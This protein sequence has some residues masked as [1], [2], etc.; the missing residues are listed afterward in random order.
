MAAT[1]Q[2]TMR[3]AASQSLRAR[4]VLLAG[5]VTIMLCACAP[6]TRP[7]RAN[8]GAGAPVPADSTDRSGGAAES[9]P[10][11]ALTREDVLWLERVGF[12]VDDRLLADYRRL[13]RKGLLEQQLAPQLPPYDMALPPA[14]AAQINALDVTHLDPQR[15]LPGVAARIRY[16]NS[17][18]PEERATARRSL[19]QLG[20]ELAR[21]AVSRELL[22]AIYS[23]AQLRE[24]M[25]WFWLNHFSVFQ[26]K[27][28]LRWLVGDYAERAI[29][30]YALGHFRD[31]LL[32]TLEHPAMLQYLDN[33]Q[34][35]LGY[36]NENYAREFMELHTLG[37]DGGYTQRD[38]QQLALVFTGVGIAMGPPPRLPRALQPLYLRRDAFEF[39]PARHDMRSVRLL[40]H[41][42]RGG[43]FDE[44]K[45]AV[46]LIVR[47]PACARFIARQLA[48]Y[49]V[50]DEPPPA[51]VARMTQTF[52]RTDGDISA[53]LRTMF[54]A[55]E[56]T[57]ALGGKFK[58]PMRYVLSATRLAY[59]DRTITDTTPLLNWLRALGELPFAHLTP[60]G[61]ALTE[62][63]WA[64]PGQLA[65]RFQIARAIAGGNARLFDSAAGGQAFALPA[66]YQS[67]SSHLYVESLEPYLAAN[68]QAVLGR[69]R[70]PQEWSALLLASPDFNYE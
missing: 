37:V 25:V 32:A 28:E 69:A 61:Y 23:P 51:L 24:Q 9:A 29:R 31:L 45:R 63:A 46:T 41:R 26:N 10:L 22:Q 17:L 7:D 12:G 33:Q 20:N 27:G 6:A 5:C 65:T 64:S 34:N 53:V 30:P 50:A 4:G 55:P 39:N 19:D 16:I 58:D 70:S 2:S 49:F 11:R 15:L 59:A 21:E 60:D 62:E 1:R 67:L 44:V 40:G 54:L 52:Q 13:G 43:G 38:V 14:I 36:I 56:F 68:T 18:S 57:A 8:S 35:R 66:G 47:Q 48:I 3:A 42:I